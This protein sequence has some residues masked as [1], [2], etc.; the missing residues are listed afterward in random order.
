MAR[1]L[2]RRVGLAAAAA[3][4]RALRETTQRAPLPTN[5]SPPPAAL[6]R[7]R[8]LRA[9]ANGTRHTRLTA[10]GERSNGPRARTLMAARRVR[11]TRLTRRMAR[12]TRTCSSRRS[13][14]TGRRGCRAFTSRSSAEQRERLRHGSM[15]PP[16]R[17]R[18]ICDSCETSSHSSQRWRCDA[19]FCALPLSSLRLS[20][21]SARC[22]PFPGSLHRVSMLRRSASVMSLR[23]RMASPATRR[24][25]SGPLARF[26]LFDETFDWRLS[27]L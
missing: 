4:S 26:L 15:P 11:A 9:S 7:R 8:V 22:E 21:C 17:L 24:S 14:G 13:T 6:Q 27:Q 5:R 16:T 20:R 3:L 2:R 10:C 19:R 18:R 1:L 25:F 23:Q 12:S